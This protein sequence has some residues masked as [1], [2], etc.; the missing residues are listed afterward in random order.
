M[1]AVFVKLSDSCAQYY[2]LTEHLAIDE[3]IVLFKDLQT[4]YSREMQVV[5]FKAVQAV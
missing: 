2:S 5:W 4:V 3:I 1:R